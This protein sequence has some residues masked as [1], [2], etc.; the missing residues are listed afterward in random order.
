MEDILIIL[1]AVTLLLAGFVS[2]MAYTIIKNLSEKLARY[3]NREKLL[4]QIVNKKMF[5]ED[6]E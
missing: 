6:N 1:G 5:G 4:N 2:G 3:E